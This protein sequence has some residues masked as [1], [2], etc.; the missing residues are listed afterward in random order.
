MANSVTQLFLEQMDY[1]LFFN[2]VAFLFLGT[3]CLSMRQNFKPSIPWRWLA[4]FAL[5]YGSNECLGVVTRIWREDFIF[6]NKIPAFLPVGYPKV[7]YGIPIPFIT[8]LF[9]FSMAMSLWVFYCQQIRQKFMEQG[10][11]HKDSY[12]MLII[13][14][15]V[16]IL[17]VGWYAT[18]LVKN[19]TEA[20]LRENVLVLT[21]TAAAA[22]PS[23]EFQ[24]D[25]KQ[26]LLGIKQA[27]ADI[28]WAY[29]MV[30]RDGK[31]IF[32]ADSIPESGDGQDEGKDAYKNPP[33]E[34]REIFMTGKGVV[35]GPYTDEWGTFVSG[36]APVRD[37]VTGSIIGI[38][39]M[40]IDAQDWQ[41]IIGKHGMAPMSIT[42]LIFLLVL[43]FFV[44]RQ[45]LWESAERTAVSEERLALAMQGA[46][47]GLWDWNVLANEVYYSPQWKR[48]LGYGEDELENTKRAYEELLHPE[49]LEK[50]RQAEQAY[51]QG[52]ADKLEIELRMCHKDGHYVDIL[53]RAFVVRR[54]GDEKPIR[55][56]GTHLDITE[57]N[58]IAR[59]LVVA[60]EAAE[61]ANRTK[62]AFL[63][64]MSHEI[65][66][67]MNAIL[68]FNQLM[69]R[70]PSLKEE[71]KQTLH[72][73]RRSGEHLL[74]L[75]NDILEM[76]KI[77][78][79]QVG[80][81]QEN[82]DLHQF[83]QEL[84]V[85]F[86]N[87]ITEKSLTFSMEIED[88]LPRYIVADKQKL[89]QIFYNLLSNA[90]KFTK[91]GCIRIGIR[92]EQQVGNQKLQLIGE[93]EDTG[94]GIS[95]KDMEKLFQPFSQTE[96]GFRTGGGTGLGLAISQDFARLMGGNITLVSQ[97][98]KGSCFR[99]QVVVEVGQEEEQGE[100]IDKGRVVALQ[101]NIETCR[102]LVVDDIQENRELLTQL[103]TSVGFATNSASNGEEAIMMVSSWSPQLIFMDV[104]MPIKDGY[105]ATREIKKTIRGEQIPIIG[106]SASILSEDKEKALKSG[107][108]RFIRKPF[109]EEEIFS[110]IA[111]CLDINYV[112]Q[113]D[114]IE[115][116]P[117]PAQNVVTP[118]SLSLEFIREMEAAI[119]KAN[120]D[121]MLALIQDLETQ[122]P[123][124]AGNMREMVNGFQY[125]KLLEL[126][127]QGGTTN[128]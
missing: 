13:P 47:D 78:A 73:I 20:E 112:Y 89:R 42:L 96:S 27:N 44:V 11:K 106:V 2:G 92:E 103:L 114:V 125:D 30:L 51:F 105:E 79:G 49:D 113:T 98:G 52:Q 85:M 4:F 21:E 66:T 123:E 35:V 101:P 82:F 41:E 88:K 86:R 17:S 122:A 124:W 38:F 126:I 46:N 84:D 69:L 70:D 95:A 75:I 28:V 31:L 19:N 127:R 53:S 81:Y 74:V 97:V 61:G 58:K 99:V 10:R 71:Q 57:R 93:V 48:M 3:I 39:A 22:I 33:L 5:L 7:I 120:F 83:M 118:I 102:I 110:A 40:D 43:G 109:R 119:I 37:P 128:E 24:L 63:A 87:K 72:T 6:V 29:Y 68:G 117:L 50:V 32:V 65:R 121:D 34:I 23:G 54:D 59:E 111:E 12:E 116:V 100:K 80:I 25:R 90:T 16:L 76:S 55:L 107:M 104:R 18:E 62:S 36:F 1:I 64:N 15:V 77:E 26:R 67:P 91:K 9:V 45:R 108:E 8:G 56:V 60:K 94:M 115:Q 14:L